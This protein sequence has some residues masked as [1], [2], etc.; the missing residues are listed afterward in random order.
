MTIQ[1]VLGPIDSSQ[2]GATL[3]HEHVTCADWSLRMGLES[4]YFE[5]DE[6]A[7]MGREF[8]SRA[9]E[10]CGIA[11]VVDGTPINLGRDPRLMQRVS[12]ESG[13]QII[14]SSG[15]YY[16][17][18]PWMGDRPFPEVEEWLI[19][20]CQEGMGDTGIRPGIMKAG[21]A[22]DG[23]TPNL[24]KVLTVNGRAAAA[25]GI[26]LFCHHAVRLK[27]GGQILDLFEKCGLDPKRVIL[28]HSGDTEDLEYLEEMLRRGCWLGM[29]R[30]AFCD[31]ML[32]LEPRVK[33][34]L[35]LCN[36]GW[37]GRLLLSHDFSAYL[38]FWGDWE[39]EKKRDCRHQ[40][41]D[42][43]YIH[44]RVLPLLRAGGMTEEDLRGMLV[45]NPRRFFEGNP[46]C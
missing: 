35:E 5:T 4:R 29:D 32:G 2:L 26:P 1:T 23:I 16:Q 28:G 3:I 18:D 39:E 43:T 38:G 36:R 31:I 9:K 8:F 27:N 25:C 20:D 30:F 37:A 21:V 22:M 34:I 44:R 19:R 17:Q 14:A 11:T 40:E 24:E 10:E 33:V 41:V 42:L 6:V 7:R 13:V 12:R 15:F 45:D 46:A